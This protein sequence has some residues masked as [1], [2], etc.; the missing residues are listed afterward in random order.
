[1]CCIF[2]LTFPLVASFCLICNFDN[3]SNL[4][5]KIGILGC[6][7]IPNRYGGFEQF[8][9]RLAPELARRGNNVWVYNSHTHPYTA[10]VWKKVRIIRCYDPED[11]IGPAGQFVYD[12][13]CILDSRKRRFDILLQL[14]YTSSSLWY[15]LLPKSPIIVTNMDGM[16]WQR[17]KYAPPV[18]SFLKYAERLAVK[19]SDALVADAVPIR[20]Y[21]LDT[22]A[23]D[24]TCIPYGAEL[25][26][27]P[28]PEVL[29]PL[30]LSPGEYFLVIARLQPDN[31]IEE[32]ITGVMDSGLNHPLVVVGNHQ[33]KYGRYLQQKFKDNRIHFIG[34]I[35]EEGLLNN[36]RCHCRLYFHGH[37]AGGTNPSLLE[38]MGAGALIAAHDNVFNRSVLDEN[39][40]FFRTSNDV[41]KIIK[42]SPN[43]AQN[44]TFIQNNLLAIK[45][46]YNWPAVI[47][48]YFTLFE[49][50]FV[51]QAK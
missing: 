42:I 31:H 22:Y 12:V 49:K 17:S 23:K 14:G 19:S 30:G 46:Q 1:M 45:Q 26:S 18:R 21:I 40:Y 36:L 2:R 16:E 27:H 44:K 9:S 37:S 3:Q 35:F 15:R 5:M 41:T 13:N 28:E 34:G 32:I 7:G 25:F 10:S 48:A 51:Q 6:R 38:A 39:A 20:D 11:K 4:S 29:A 24:S 47:D 43:T 50:L 33:N 8:V